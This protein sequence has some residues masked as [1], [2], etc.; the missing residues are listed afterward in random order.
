MEALLER[1]RVIATAA[2]TWIQ[3]GMAV[4]VWFS[5][6]IVELLPVD[7]ERAGAVIVKV[8]AI[9]TGVITALRRVTPVPPAERGLLTKEGNH[10]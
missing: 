3:V 2:I 4:V 6:D 7:Q 8:L 9:C 1:A 10:G 5:Q